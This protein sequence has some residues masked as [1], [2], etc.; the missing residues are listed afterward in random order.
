MKIFT[1]VNGSVTPGAAVSKHS[2]TGAGI[3][4]PVILVG[5]AGR[6]R[7]LGVLPVAQDAIPMVPCPSQGSRYLTSGR[8]CEQ[9]GIMLGPA[10]EGGGYSVPTAE[11]PQT[12]E[13]FGLLVAADVD[14]SR[15][16]HPKLVAEGAASADECLI[17][18]LTTPG[19]RGGA[20]HT[21][22][23][24]PQSEG[25]DLFFSPFPGRT[26]CSGSV[27]QGDAGRMG[28][29]EQLVVVMPRGVVF[30]T[31]RSGRLYGKPGSHYYVFDGSA[32][33]AATW[34]E[35]QAADLF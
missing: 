3:A 13:A 29:C 34:E 5:E 28:G 20:S 7:K 30:R 18:L 23:R 35:R 27:A 24:L 4:I 33:L 2:L 12:G 25:E 26:I 6:G 22:D 19:F 15:A 10:L 32:I 17:V 16:G 8:P 1:V 9:C 11:H 31:S 21:G 14:S